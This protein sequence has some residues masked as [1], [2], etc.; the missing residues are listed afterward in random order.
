MSLN[1]PDWGGKGAAADGMQRGLDDN[2]TSVERKRGET[3]REGQRLR[4]GGLRRER[5]K[6][7][8][9][10]ERGRESVRGERAGAGWGR[11][12]INETERE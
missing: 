8:R 3:E 9:E 7:Q 1:Q 4:D 10:R 5:N 2:A 11:G 12:E 6:D